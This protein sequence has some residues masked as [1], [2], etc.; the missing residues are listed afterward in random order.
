MFHLGGV[1]HQW[2][3]W[4]LNSHAMSCPASPSGYQLSF[5]HLFV[6]EMMVNTYNL[7]LFKWDP[8]VFQI[9]YLSVF[10]ICYIMFLKT[11]KE[12]IRIS[13]SS[14]AAPRFPPHPW[15]QNQP[16][17]PDRI[18]WQTVLSLWLRCKMGFEASL[19]KSDHYTCFLAESDLAV[20]FITPYI[21]YYRDG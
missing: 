15:T 13:S 3:N 2:A 16:G 11:I 8:C 5:K 20:G 9:H 1:P 14:C 18:I 7:V 4:A 10:Q 6:I 19:T 21:C 17:C 12:P